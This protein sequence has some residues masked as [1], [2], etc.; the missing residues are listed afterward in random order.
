MRNPAKEKPRKMPS[1][2]RHRKDP[3]LKERDQAQMQEIEAQ[4]RG[5]LGT[6]LSGFAKEVAADIKRFPKDVEEDARRP[7]RRVER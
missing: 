6:E 5:D 3:A 4:D 2:S 1:A 7:E